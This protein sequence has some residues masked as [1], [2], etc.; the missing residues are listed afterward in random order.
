M[1]SFIKNRNHTTSVFHT[2]HDFTPELAWA[3]FQLLAEID[4]DYVTPTQLQTIGNIIA[5]PLSKRSDLNKLLSA[6]CDIGLV[7]RSNKGMFLS[8]SAKALANGL[9]KYEQGFRA[10]IHCIYYWKWIWE[11]NYEIATPSWSYREV[12]RQI[13]E[14]GLRGINSDE[15]V[16][17]VVS[18]AEQF[19]V[20]KISFSRSSV[21]GV[22]T[23]L[24]AQLPSLI[25]KKG[26]FI[27]PQYFHI[28][29][30]NT[31]RLN[32]AALCALG[33]G[34]TNLNSE[35]IKLLSESFLIASDGLTDF[36][37]NYVNNSEEFMYIQ[38][39]PN[40]IIFLG[41]ED[42]FIKWIVRESI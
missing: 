41:S 5:S 38:G 15:I 34:K 40:Q 26:N 6:M 28:P 31:L 1:N 22:T 17:R 33:R 12:C 24:E 8:V 20:N 30:D 7:E 29:M 32:L 21:N 14:S 35:N 2:K 19:N 16:I 39:I 27:F 11:G 37:I 4:L 36:I 13:L 10:A 3:A 23:W 25:Q 42:P 9:G 18:S